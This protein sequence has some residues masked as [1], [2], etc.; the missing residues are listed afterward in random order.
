MGIDAVVAAGD[1]KAAR[2]VFKRNKALL[3]VAGKPIIRHIVEVLLSCKDLDRI[4]VVGPKERFEEVIGD[5]DVDIVE[6]KRSLAENGWEGFLQTLPEY[7]QSGQLT[8][9]II[10]NYQDKY[11]LFLSGDIP[12]IS[13]REVEE[14][15]SKCDMEHYDHVAGIT[16]EEILKLFG[17]RKGRP[18][19]KM[20]TFHTWDG[21]FRQ[22]N[23]HMARPFMLI[24]GIDLV[25]KAYEYRYQKELFNIFKTL[26][27]FIK[28]G[29]KDLGKILAIYLTLQVSAG[30][31]A[32][33]FDNLA[34]LI[35]FPV[36]IDRI[37]RIVSGLLGARFK[38]V[39]TTVGGAALDVDNE[40][41]FMI[42]SV[43]YRD[44]L[45]QISSER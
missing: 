9:D 26:V 7:R 24:E 33:G 43:M 27:T 40:K 21:N 6:Q 15:I 3:D 10:D 31:N 5:L 16:S 35:S 29:P 41:D 25:L 28:M 34:H 45:N 30:L 23:L 22:N 37:E 8:V 32:L 19:I 14:F 13:V 42:L 38:V 20:A 2:K 11:V 1:G 44:W 39:E 4:I 36:T 18:G 12:L 17:P